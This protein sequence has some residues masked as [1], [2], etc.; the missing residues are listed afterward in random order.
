M[1]YTRECEKNEQVLSCVRMFICGHIA[2][3]ETQIQYQLQRLRTLPSRGWRCSPIRV[4]GAKALSGNQMFESIFQ[5]QRIFTN[6]NPESTLTLL[7]AEV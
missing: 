6:F 1:V 7:R 4:Y 2:L 3:D 5:N